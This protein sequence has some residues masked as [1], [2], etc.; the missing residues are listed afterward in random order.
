MDKIAGLN[1]LFDPTVAKTGTPLDQL[2]GLRPVT[3]EERA[4]RKHRS[5]ERL[6]ALM[7]D[8]LPDLGTPG[9][10]GAERKLSTLA[11]NQSLSPHA[12]AALD[13]I[14]GPES[15]GAYNVRYGGAKG[16]QYF[17]DYSQ[18]P[19][20][21]E[22]I[23]AG[24]EAGQTSGAAGRYQLLYPTW[25]KQANLLGLKNYGPENQDLAAWNLMK[26]T[27]ASN[28]GG[29]DLESDLKSNN[30]TIHARINDALKG[31]WR[32]ASF[33]PQKFQNALTRQMGGAPAVQTP[34]GSPADQLL[35]STGLQSAQPDMSRYEPVMLSTG[36][37]A[38]MEK[39][40]TPEEVTNSLKAQN[41]D[42][43]P[44]RR[45]NVP[46]ENPIYVPHDMNDTE[47]MA[48]LRKQH[49]NLA[50]PEHKGEEHTGYL[51][52]IKQGALLG[53]SNVVRGITDIGEYAAGKLGPDSGMGQLIGEKSR[54]GHEWAEQMAKRGEEAFQEPADASWA[55]KNLGYPFMKVAGQ[56][57]PFVASSI[58]PGGVIPRGAAVLST[59]AG[60]ATGQ[61]EDKAKEVGKP[62]DIEEAAPTILADMGI[63]YLGQYVF[64]PLQKM[65]G[66]EATQAPKQFVQGLVAQHGADGAKAMMGSYLTDMLKKAGLTG[67][68]EVGNE[69][70]EEA[71]Y[72]GY[73]GQDL[74]SPEAIQSYIE[75]A[76]QVA[77]FGVGMGGVHGAIQQHAKQEA[78]TR[79][80]EDTAQGNALT[81]QEAAEAKAQLDNEMRQ[82][83]VTPDILQKHW[84]DTVKEIGDIPEDQRT[85]EQ[86][87]RWT[88][89]QTGE[90]R[91][92]FDDY[93]A[94][95][96]QQK[97][98]QE[99]ELPEEL[100]G[101]PKG[102]SDV[103]QKIREEKGK[104]YAGLG[105]PER[106]PGMKI[107]RNALDSYDINDPQHVNTIASVLDEIE[108]NHP[109][110]PQGMAD[111][112]T[113][114]QEMRDAHGIKAPT[115]PD[116]GGGTQPPGGEE[117]GGIGQGGQGIPGGGQESGTPQDQEVAPPISRYD[118]ANRIAAIP[119]GSDRITTAPNKDLKTA[120]HSNDIS[121]M[122]KALSKSENPIVRHVAT[123]AQRIPGL[124]IEVNSPRLD[125]AA[126][127]M[128]I[129]NPSRV[130]GMYV[131]GLRHL[132][133]RPKTANNEWVVTHELMHGMAS[134]ILQ[135]PEPHQVQAVKGLK[136]LHRIVASHPLTRSE[137][138]STNVSEFVSEGFS[139]PEFQ[140]RLSKIKLGR[141][142]A[143]NK[144]TQAIARLFGYKGDQNAFT[145]F[146]THAGHILETAHRGEPVSEPLS[147]SRS[148]VGEPTHIDVNGEMRP[149]HDS[150]GQRIHTTD[151]GVKNFWKNFEGTKVVDEEGRPL[152]VFHGSDKAFT[153]FDTE[154]G[155][156]G[157]NRLGPGAYFTHD[158]KR[159]KGY[160]ENVVP[161]YLDL[162]NPYLAFS[163]KGPDYGY[164]SP[165]RSAELKAQGHDGI[166]LL[167]DREQPI[168]YV[169]F[170]PE[171]IKSATDNVGTFDTA[172]PDI[173]FLE[174]PTEASEV[175]PTPEQR[176][177]ILDEVR[178]SG[179]TGAAQKGKLGESLGS[180]LYKAVF[181]GDMTAFQAAVVD[182]KAPLAKA[183]R[184]L[185]ASVGK[186]L[187]A[188]LIY[189]A[190]SQRG[191]TMQQGLH[192]GYTTIDSDGTLAAIENSQLAPK[193]IFDRIREH[194]KTLGISEEEARKI[195]NEMLVRLRA[196]TIREQ[197]AKTRADATNLLSRAD[198]LDEHANTRA[199][200][201]EQNKF[202]KAAAALRRLGNKKLD[203]LGDGRTYVTPEQ[204]STGHQLYRMYKDTLSREVDNIHELLRTVPPMLR[205]A[206][207]INKAQEK[208]FMD[209][210]F[211]FPF[212]DRAQFDQDMIDPLKE[213]VIQGYLRGMGRGL[214][215]V[216]EVKRQESHQHE[217]YAPENLIR[218]LLYWA[219]AASEHVARKAA[220]KQLE[221]VGGATRLPGEPTD[222]NFVVK[223]KEHGNDT[224][225]R[226]QDPT[227]FYAFQ[228]SAPITGPVIDTLRKF[229]KLQREVA[230]FNPFFWFKQIIREPKQASRLAKVGVI[231]PLDTMS[232]LVKIAMGKS[233]GYK[234]IAQKGIMGPVDLAADTQERLKHLM[235]GRQGALQKLEENLHHIHE[236]VDAA[237]RV[238]VYDRALAKYK[239]MGIDHETADALAIKD[240][241]ELMNFSR[242]GKSTTLRYLRAITPFLGSYINGLDVMAKA[243][244]P[245]SYGNLSKADA[246]EAR[247]EFYGTS[248][249]LI[250]VGM[251][252]ALMMSD[253]EKWAA[254]EDR[255]G[256]VLVRNPFPNNDKHP[257]IALP[258]E[259]EIGWLQHTLPE[260]ML[261]TALG[262]IGKDTMKANLAESAGAMLMPPLGLAATL[263]KTVRWILDQ[264]DAKFNYGTHRGEGAPG[265]LPAYQDAR[266]S[267]VVKRFH[268]V[269]SDMGLTVMSPDETEKALQQLLGSVWTVAR[270]ASD[271]FLESKGPEKTVTEK[272][273]FGTGVF[274]RQFNDVAVRDAYNVMNDIQT[275]QNTLSKAKASTDFAKVSSILS[276]PEYQKAIF[277]DN[278]LKNMTEALADNTKKMARATSG[279]GFTPKERR[280]I[281][282]RL[283]EERI[284]ICKEILKKAKDLGVYE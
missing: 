163:A 117:D 233:E 100:R 240:A 198:E 80:Q 237:T 186:H 122:F 118:F 263:N 264:E 143:W 185:G 220:C 51:D 22:R 103:F 201:E 65:L 87:A 74:F 34:A 33:N 144:F 270:S 252:Y 277:A 278:M 12:R 120:L 183:L 54:A 213:E 101:L 203:D 243:M 231:T 222:K 32:T 94:Q 78:L 50:P 77:P 196:G 104:Y 153:Q 265:T 194:A 82:A 49:P 88:A 53:T 189:S 229:A 149:V 137:Y 171:Q 200:E 19:H 83:R 39:G 48:E 184:S 20:I 190:W 41:I 95:R 250:A 160:G 15:S 136:E 7:A 113:K 148:E 140:Y 154:A 242:N 47:A 244:A 266:A 225:Y 110:N 38:Y 205:K 159:A 269:F 102:T 235:E 284:L 130:G 216:A 55:A 176:K 152:R 37:Q 106:G 14:A 188:D 79:A 70:A 114:L 227:V 209:Y 187:R 75:T 66:P 174:E 121:G 179:L 59:L 73:G 107:I 228:N 44:M 97:A 112:R 175:P 42:A 254:R 9:A 72:R 208:S 5:E 181:S 81:A 182:E 261:L 162:K 193:K 221:L 92:I 169:A 138:G 29:R 115:T 157:G 199:S 3:E 142:S 155:K 223:V 283:Q 43:T 96:E 2:F 36:Q 124:H 93:V 57:L 210:A 132:V 31:Q 241:R 86:R 226:I 239:K 273:P 40:M 257:F 129:R 141:Q 133:V 69:I 151:E 224:F 262:T 64:G 21:Q 147:I 180:M 191:N 111:L 126:R 204:V 177:A 134:H 45:F 192:R 131:H 11:V 161:A 108:S 6:A 17:D 30:P 260:N 165:K 56:A 116:V 150:T 109:H 178:E 230:V 170:Y 246:M 89:M 135:N 18:H 23:N 146:L 219:S 197:D 282:D 35:P 249:A 207:L 71:L 267:E 274:P 24:T 256:N 172:K 60:A 245:G 255:N 276:K 67:A 279:E 195:V 272:L 217:I 16:P 68:A 25:Q 271:T 139:N 236:A 63:N 1:A 156:T 91:Q 251:G 202:R 212:Y 214:K 85:D 62:F 259:F 218:H 119:L 61:A 280:E 215:S 13:I 232:E 281:N 164:I 127:M 98:Q 27:Y 8:E 105:L 145:E 125:A 84:E 258:L 247:R 123:H 158:A 28:S 128:G 206:G 46:G 238:V 10:S 52:A 168:E 234:R 167:N 268:K 248:A 275:V 90:K 4:E 173:S 99:A 253:D 211:Y 76:K 26:T 166:V 58:V